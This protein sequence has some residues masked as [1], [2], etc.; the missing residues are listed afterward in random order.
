MLPTR[1]APRAT[2]VIPALIFGLAGLIAIS[3][4]LAH[5]WSEKRILSAFVHSSLSPRESTFATA[6]DLVGLISAAREGSE[7]GPM[8]K[9]AD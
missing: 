1:L 4:L 8:S 6:L 9:I 2:A 7:H 3:I 5:C